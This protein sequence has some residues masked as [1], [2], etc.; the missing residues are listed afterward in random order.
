MNEVKSVLDYNDKI[1]TVE[2][3]LKTS[4]MDLDKFTCAKT[5]M[6]LN[7]NLVKNT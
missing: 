2:E 5:N 6:E 4:N 3:N 7:Y 1:S